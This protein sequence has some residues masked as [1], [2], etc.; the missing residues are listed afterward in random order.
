MK[1]RTRTKRLILGG[2]GLMAVTAAAL[3]SA[4][5]GS[6]ASTISAAQVQSLVTTNA[7]ELGER[8]P[9][10]VSYSALTTRNAANEAASGTPILGSYGS[11]CQMLW[12]WQ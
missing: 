3:V 9:T 12:I 11:Y 6:G 1:M 2:T 7:A 8:S 5:T 10:N 4:A